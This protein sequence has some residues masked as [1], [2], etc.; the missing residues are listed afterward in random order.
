[1]EKE[2]TGEILTDEKYLRI[3]NSRGQ[4]SK[5]EKS[6]SRRKNEV[7]KYVNR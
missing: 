3:S 2:K 4:K 6:N 7:G 1:M 5:N